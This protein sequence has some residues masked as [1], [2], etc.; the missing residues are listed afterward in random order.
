[1]LTNYII[2]KNNNAGDCSEVTRSHEIPISLSYRVIIEEVF[3]IAMHVTQNTIY[4]L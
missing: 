3:G 2:R 4:S 1:M